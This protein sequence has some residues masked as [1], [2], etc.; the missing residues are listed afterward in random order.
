MDLTEQPAGEFRRNPWETSRARFFESTLSALTR[1]NAVLDVGA[2]DAFV[3]TTLQANLWPHARF[4]CVDSGYERFPPPP[5]DGVTFA[6]E[7]PEGPFDLALLLD[8]LEHVDN[9][10]AL[11]SSVTARV[12][13]GGHLLISVPSW[14]R[15]YS[16]HDERLG[17][18]RRY[19]PV[20]A[21]RLVRNAGLALM[22][23][24]GLFHGLLPVRAAQVALERVKTP[25][26]HDELA[27]TG[28]EWAATT[29]ESVFAAEG[30]VSRWAAEWGLTLPGLS[31]WALCRKP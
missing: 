2:G 3:T 8:V 27:W 4:V 7:V 5:R 18:R 1:V 20:M 23:S 31:W 21:R 9:D 12:R 22:R 19:T 25:S 29:L 24:G 10:A 16:S 28:P 14:P 17:H 15:L 13:S 11:L 30:K 6:T 26:P